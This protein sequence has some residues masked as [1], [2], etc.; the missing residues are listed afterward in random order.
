[1]QLIRYWAQKPLG[2]NLSIGILERKIKVAEEVFVID[3]LIE[4]PTIHTVV[5]KVF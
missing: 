4:K 5:I 2:V 3:D 1:V